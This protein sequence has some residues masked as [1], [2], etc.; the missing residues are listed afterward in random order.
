[1]LSKTVSWKL[2]GLIEEADISLGIGILGMPGSTAYGGLD[3]LKPKKGET[4]FISAAAGIVGGLV[5]MLMKQ[6]YDC[7]VIGSC[8]GP[9]KCALIKEKFGFDHAI[10]YKLYN[11]E[12]ELTAALKEVAPD[13]IDMYFENVGG[14]HFETAFNSLKN[15]GRICVCGQI[16]EYNSLVPNLNKINPMKMIYSQQRIEG[17]ICF[18]YL[19]GAKGT[20]LK[21]MHAWLKEGKVVK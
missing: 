10:D 19:A 12:E 9:D 15:G 17:L 3:V 18:G 14:Y 1:M 16:A 13:G 8:G 6:V 21:D 11:S 2:T 7:K 4:I 20:F 5:G